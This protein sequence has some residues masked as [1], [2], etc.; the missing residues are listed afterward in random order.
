MRK[1]PCCKREE[2][3][4]KGLET[5]KDE[6]SS[7]SDAL[8]KLWNSNRVVKNISAKPENICSLRLEIF[9]TIL[10]DDMY[11]KNVTNLHQISRL[12]PNICWRKVV[13]K[14]RILKDYRVR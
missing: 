2:M 13:D 6:P 7:P 9:F 12:E 3:E 10:N 5:D 8:N 11:V 4:A 1:M 14:D